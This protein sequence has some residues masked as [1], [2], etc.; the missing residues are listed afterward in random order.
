[1]KTV[2]HALVIG[3]LLAFLIAVI[4]T[5]AGALAL[6]IEWILEEQIP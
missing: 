4:W 2:R 5:V 1:M 6:A 3:L